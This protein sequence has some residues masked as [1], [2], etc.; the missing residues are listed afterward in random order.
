MTKILTVSLLLLAVISCSEINKPSEKP[1]RYEYKYVPKASDCLD[2]LSL[3][4]N[5]DMT[6]QVKLRIKI[7][8]V[9]IGKNVI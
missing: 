3:R 4:G 7:E 2:S 9:Q 1:D 5:D 6:G 8:S